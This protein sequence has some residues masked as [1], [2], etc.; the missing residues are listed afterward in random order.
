MLE[1]TFQIVPGLGA[2]RERR[3]WAAGCTHWRDLPGAEPALLPS[4]LRESLLTAATSLAEALC[5]SD[6][7]TVAAALPAG[8]RWRMFAAFEERAVYLDIETLG[9][10]DSSQALTAIG[11]LDRDGPRILLP[12]RGLESFP[13]QIPPGAVLVTFNGAAFDVPVLQRFFPGWRPPAAHIDLC[14]LLAR[15]GE[16]GGLKAIEQRLGLGRPD[17]LRSIDGWGAASLFRWAGRG[18]RAALRLFAEY[19]LYDT[20]NL[21]TLMGLA[22]NRAVEALGVPAGRVSVSWRGD[23][24]YDVSKALLAL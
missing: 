2:R 13:E 8:E 10:R 3:L 24:L 14:P 15:L 11:I 4:R 20:V 19:N 16:R 23:V 5:A 6:V 12:W 1:A 9:S 7:E 18:D 17:H 22:Y 21:R